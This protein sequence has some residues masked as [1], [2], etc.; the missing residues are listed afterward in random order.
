M[1]IWRWAKANGI[2]HGLP[3][4]KVG[5][6]INQKFF[7]GHAK[8][9]WITDIL[10]GRKTPYRELSND[11]WKKQYNR[12]QITSQAEALTRDRSVGPVGKAFD[13]PRRVATLGHGLVFPVTHGGDLALRPQSWGIFFKGLFNTYTKA[14][15]NRA[16]TERLLDTMRRSP[17]FDTALRSGLDVSA[18]A[19]AGNWINRPA[20]GSVSTRAWDVLTTMRYELWDRAMQ[21]FTNPT[22]SQAET[23]EVGKQL[24]EWANH[25]TGSAKGP[26]AAMGGKVFFGPA[27]TQSKLNRIV[28]DP[29]K[30]AITLGKMA[31]GKE[32]TPGERAVA[33]T[34]FSGITQ[35]ATTMLGFLAANQ[36]LNIALGKKDPKDQINFTDPNKSDW[37]AFKAGGVE[38]SMP[39]MHSEIRTIGEILKTTYIAATMS[40]NQAKKALFG[41]SP[42]ARLAGIAGNY[43]LGK[44][45]PTLQLGKELLMQRAFPDRPLP[46]SSDPGT[47]KSPR[48]DWWQYAIS[49]APIPLTGALGYFYDQMKAA[50]ADPS[51]RIDVMRGLILSAIDVTGVHAKDVNPPKPSEAALKAE[52]AANRRANAAAKIADRIKR[53]RT[54]EALRNR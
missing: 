47:L 51:R 30:T 37:L 52:K 27:L 44:L 43:G 25:A 20:T 22:M 18:R 8:G 45:H 9:E 40:E 49:H 13:F 34:R 17:L 28:V 26:I 32:T 42:Q 24:A 11:A 29:I 36:G 6:A 15:V 5:D 7:A 38:F 31:L 4:D 48:L 54:A 50:Q 33:W 23:L 19:H 35:Y 2:D 21:K 39:G 1:A 53:E 14:T 12:R 41:Q 10:S 16:A 46:W 3:I